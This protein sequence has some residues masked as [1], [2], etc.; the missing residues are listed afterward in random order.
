[1]W[2]TF[3]F[4]CQLCNK[5]NI[6][7]FSIKQIKTSEGPNMDTDVHFRRDPVHCLIRPKPHTTKAQK[8]ADD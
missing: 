7:E 8:K 6:F 5:V 2:L 1:M 3:I 4:L